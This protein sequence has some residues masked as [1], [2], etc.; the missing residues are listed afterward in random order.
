M[1]EFAQN[2]KWKPVCPQ[3]TTENHRV[4]FA[5]LEGNID[6][7]ALDLSEFGSFDLRNCL[8]DEATWDAR[9]PPAADGTK[10]PR[11]PQPPA[12]IPAEAISRVRALYNENK[13]IAALAMNNERVLRNQMAQAFGIIGERIAIPGTGLKTISTADLMSRMKAICVTTISDIDS[14]QAK[15]ITWDQSKD[16]ETNVISRNRTIYLLNQN[17]L[18]TQDFEKISSFI[19]ATKGDVQI[20]E[21]LK[22][23]HIGHA[24]YASQIYDEMIQFFRDQLP[25][26][27]A[28]AAASA[29]AMHASAD[30]A[31]LA[32]LKLEKALNWS[33][34]A[35][36]AAAAAVPSNGGQRGGPGRGRR[37][38]RGGRNSAGRS[39]ARPTFYCYHHGSKSGHA[40]SICNDMKN[41]SSFTQEMR[42]ATGPQRLKGN[43]G[44]WYNGAS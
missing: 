26:V 13:R 44:I 34:S 19:A 14:L 43:N 9:N 8:I 22:A 17:H 2:N 41:D 36:A 3:L 28:A 29:S 30:A 15:L 1:T 20:T 31:E 21:V 37:G 18:C 40:G 5:E 42:D 11:Y 35:A 27:Q 39:T 16:F 10:V 6:E 24:T 25:M 32:A 38:G 23:Y 7:R 12:A 4:S 33:N